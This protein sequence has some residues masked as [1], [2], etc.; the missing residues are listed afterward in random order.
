VTN[1][2]TCKA[3]MGTGIKG[4]WEG[5]GDKKQWKIRACRS[6]GGGGQKVKPEKK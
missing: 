5:T 4:R 3:C 2:V 6:C 1:Y